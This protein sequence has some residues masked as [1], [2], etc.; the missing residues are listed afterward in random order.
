VPFKGVHGF[1][2]THDTI[3]KL[4]HQH[5]YHPYAQQYLTIAS[6][7]IGSTNSKVLLPFCDTLCLAQKDHNWKTEGKAKS[8]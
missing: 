7:F 4:G 1:V 2:D 8:S 6:K 3:I 5:I